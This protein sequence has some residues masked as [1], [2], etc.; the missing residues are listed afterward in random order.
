LVV[1]SILFSILSSTDV[2]SAYKLVGGQESNLRPASFS[3]EIKDESPQNMV[4]VIDMRNVASNLFLNNVTAKIGFY[5][6]D[7]KRCLKIRP[8]SL[9]SNI[10]GG[11]TYRI[12]RP[13]PP[14]STDY[15]YVKAENLTWDGGDLLGGKGDDNGVIKKDFIRIIAKAKV[16]QPP[17]GNTQPGRQ[18]PYMGPLEL[19]T[20][21]NGSDLFNPGIQVKNASECSNMCEQ[22]VRCQAMTFVQHPNANGG[23]CWLK[24][25]VPSPSPHTVMTSAVKVFPQAGRNPKGK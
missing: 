6:D 14:L 15:A 20:N 8:F 24:G 9:G 7:Q 21:R 11:K 5:G 13:L 25:S 12:P 2:L 3:V 16:I 19:A 22:N 1:I 23:I 17:S 18:Q 10:R 4:L